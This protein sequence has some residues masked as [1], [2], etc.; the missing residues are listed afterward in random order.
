MPLNSIHGKDG[1]HSAHDNLLDTSCR[2]AGL[3]RPLRHRRYD[4]LF[5]TPNR[6]LKQ[7]N[8]NEEQKP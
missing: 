1:E 8:L 4:R 3:L 2:T 5:R 6:G 7:R